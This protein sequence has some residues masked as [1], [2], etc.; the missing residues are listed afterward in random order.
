M[1]F[2]RDVLSRLKGSTL[3]NA[4]TFPDMPHEKRSFEILSHVCLY[5]IHLISVHHCWWSRLG[6][7]LFG[8]PPR[9][10]GNPSCKKHHPQTASCCLHV[11]RRPPRSQCRQS[12]VPRSAERVTW[13]GWIPPLAEEQGVPR[14]CRCRPGRG[15]C[16]DAGGCWCSRH[17]SRTEARGGFVKLRRD[18]NVINCGSREHRKRRRHRKLQI[19]LL[20]SGCAEVLLWIGGSKQAAHRKIMMW[21]IGY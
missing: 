7:S 6:S 17:P 10:L 21:R 9:L 13:G 11:G 19:F 20:R 15:W 14:C 18:K 16:T 12:E 3:G 1:H 5:F 4:D 8:D 2:H